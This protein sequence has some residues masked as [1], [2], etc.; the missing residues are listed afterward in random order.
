MRL[1]CSL[2][3]FAC[4]WIAIAPACG[5]DGDRG[6][7][8]FGSAGGNP[9]VPGEQRACACPGGAP[10]GVQ[11]C[12]DGGASFGPCTG[13]PGD[14]SGGSSGVSGSSSGSDGSSS[15]TSTTSASA[16]GSTTDP[17]CAGHCSNG[18]QDCGE[19]FTDCGG[20]CPATD[21]YTFCDCLVDTPRNGS[22]ICDDSGFTVPAQ[23]IPNVLV[24]LEA[25]GGQIYIANN[26]SID[27]NDNA[28]R[29]SGWELMGQNPWDYLDYIVPPL[30]CSAEQL[31]QPFD[32]SN[33]VGE[34]L[35]FGAH[36]HPDGGGS[37]TTACI[38]IAK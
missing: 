7:T 28:P 27:P 14:D 4:G 38:A 16:D 24:C 35:W 9:C 8:T 13:C 3:G 32:I 36:N 34:T 29:C 23:S 33:R 31:T 6:T 19:P 30:T 20:D 26:T 25:T 1:R 37:G 18:V 12:E 17:A 21:T 2:A 22:E 11:V 10:D 15:A 5:G